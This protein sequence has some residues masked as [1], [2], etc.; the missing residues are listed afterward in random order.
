MTDPLRGSATVS[1]LAFVQAIA[2]LR[3]PM[4]GGGFY[5]VTVA[6]LAEHLDIHPNRIRSKM[7]RAE[8]RG[9][10]DGCNCGCR[11]DVGLQP[12]G[13]ELLALS[14]AELTSAIR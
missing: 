1:D 3:R 8:R 12:A 6:A 7:R 10:T 2:A 9:L 11:G 5:S 4:R 14:A 13:E